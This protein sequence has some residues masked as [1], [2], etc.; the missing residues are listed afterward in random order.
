MTVLVV[1]LF[2]LAGCASAAPA[3][4][5]RTVPSATCDQRMVEHNRRVCFERGSGFTEP[6]A[7]GSCGRCAP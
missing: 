7:P 1:A 3:P 6:A 4:T 5:L 2:I